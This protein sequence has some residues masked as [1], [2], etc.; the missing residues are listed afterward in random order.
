MTIY[1]KHASTW[2][3][4]SSTYTRHPSLQNLSCSSPRSA[5][6]WRRLI[7]VYVSTWTCFQY[8]NCLKSVPTSDLLTELPGITDEGLVKVLAP[9][10]QVSEKLEGL[11]LRSNRQLTE[12]SMLHIEKHCTSL[13]LLDVKMEL[14]NCEGEG[15]KSGRRERRRTFLLTLGGT[16]L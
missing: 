10:K 15:C 11:V 9:N 1:W 4:L 7:W 13:R 2:S 14:K 12:T 5:G 16:T 6:I 8:V 3:L